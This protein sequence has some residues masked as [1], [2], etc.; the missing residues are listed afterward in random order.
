MMPIRIQ[1]LADTDPDQDPDWRQ[2]DADPQADPTP[3]F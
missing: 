2:K 3:T 1:S